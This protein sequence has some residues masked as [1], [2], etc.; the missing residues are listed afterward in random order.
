MLGLE[1]GNLGQGLRN[2]GADQT[3][4]A[5]S[6]IGHSLVEDTEPAIRRGK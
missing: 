5:G 2:M 1:L 6:N 4:D 3:L